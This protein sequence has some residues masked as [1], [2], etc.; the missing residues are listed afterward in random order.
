MLEARKLG[1]ARRKPFLKDPSDFEDLCSIPGACYVSD[2]IVI[3]GVRV[4]YMY[5][6]DPDNRLD[7]GWRFLSGD[8]SEEYMDDSWNLGL[9][10]LNTICNY[11]RDVIPFLGSEWPSEFARNSTSGILEPI[12]RHP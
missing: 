8:E 2:R 7:S 11:D 1:D 3:D 10:E 6:E 12:A 4:G 9:Y 5:R